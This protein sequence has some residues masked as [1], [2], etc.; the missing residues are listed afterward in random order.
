[1]NAPRFPLSSTTR[2]VVALVLL[3]SFLASSFETVA[4]LVRDGSVHHE[5]VT[6]A[7]AH[8]SEG[9]GEHG[10]ETDAEAPE[11]D[12]GPDHQH[13]TGAD[14]CTH[15]HGAALFAPTAVALTE[16]TEVV[17]RLERQFLT[18]PEVTQVVSRIGRGE[19]GAHADPVNNAEIFVDLKPD[20]EWETADNREALV[21]AMQERVGLVP[22]VQLNFT[23]PIAAAV[24]E[25]L[26]GIKAQLAV[27]I[28]SA[29]TA[30]RCPGTAFRSR[31]P[32]R[33]SAP[34]WAE[35]RPAS[36]SRA[37]VVRGG[38][39]GR[40]RLGGGAPGRLSHEL[41]RSVRAGPGG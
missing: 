38:G 40:D 39:A 15:A 21:L 9:A 28:A 8:S 32:R 7:F 12:H 26:T 23:Q 33:R 1:M 3:V 34:L 27:K 30:E 6:A 13:G 20:D 14:H 25:L 5:T 41:R 17:E 16:S 29:S 11:Q 18:F 36:F 22:G 31:M 35:R 2:K 10:H 4:G 24:D 19:I 37:S